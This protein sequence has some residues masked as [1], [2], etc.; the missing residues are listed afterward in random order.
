MLLKARTESDELLTLRFLNIRTE[1]TSKEKYYYQNLERGYEGELRF[2]SMIQ[3]LGEER[4]VIN[5]LWLEMNNSF[6]QIDSTVISQGAINLLDIKNFQ[7]DCYLDSDN[8]YSVSTGREYKNPINQLNRCAS[9]FRQLLQSLNLNYLVDASIIFIHPEFTLYQA[10]L[11]KPFI[12]PTQL[13]RFLRDLNK[14][15]SQLNDGHRKLAQTLLELHQTKNPFAKL[16]AYTY[17]QIKPGTYCKNC[18]SFQVSIRHHHL[19]CNSC[20]EQEKID[21]A[22][23]RNVKEFS[24]LFPDQKITTQAIFDWCKL[25]LCKRTYSR[26]LKKNYNSIGTTRNTY[27]S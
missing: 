7:G 19:F 5:D 22:I 20:G 25:D 3:D 11:D 21:Q 1:L 4:Y 17:D 16:P 24:L 18:K 10:P 27:Y 9:L 15:S 13:N 6:F 23:M 2:D 26:V 14:G 12:L 8:L